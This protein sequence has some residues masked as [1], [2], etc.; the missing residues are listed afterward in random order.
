VVLV[1]RSYHTHLVRLG[2]ANQLSYYAV[3]VTDGVLTDLVVL[4]GRQPGEIAEPRAT[5]ASYLRR[6]GV[7]PRRAWQNSPP[8]SGTTEAC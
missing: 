5:R 2:G 1:E 4:F 7:G 8:D 6:M 3:R